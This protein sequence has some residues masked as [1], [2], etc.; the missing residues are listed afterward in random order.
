MEMWLCRDLFGIRRYGELSRV[1]SHSLFS[2]LPT[3]LHAHVSDVC[4]SVLPPLPF[5]KG[6]CKLTWW[7][8]FQFYRK[9]NL[10]LYWVITNRDVPGAVLSHILF[11]YIAR[12]TCK[13]WHLFFSGENCWC[14]WWIL[15]FSLCFLLDRCAISF[16]PAFFSFFL[17]PS[18]ICA[19][20][21]LRPAFQFDFASAALI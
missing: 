16:P 5:T 17:S 6:V 10:F 21:T 18:I 3:A 11:R 9:E 7:P 4:E 1:A 19:P 15:I 20:V 13:E 12:Q 14:F 8:Y 2:S